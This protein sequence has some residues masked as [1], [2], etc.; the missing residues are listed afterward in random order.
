MR[1]KVLALTFALLL[2]SCGLALAQAA[3]Q[4]QAGQG[5]SGQGQQA[6]GQPAHGQGQ[7]GPSEANDPLAGSPLVVDIGFRVS[8]VD[9]DRARFERFQDIRSSGLNLN[10]FGSKEGERWAADYS[11]KNVGYHDQQYRGS[12]SGMGK[13]FANVSFFQLPLN[14]GFE[15]DG[16]VRTAYD[17][18]LQLDD[19]TQA[20]AQAGRVLAW[21]AN[22]TQSSAWVPLAHPIDLGSRRDQLDAGLVY[23]PTRTV[24]VN[25]GVTTYSRTGNQPWGASWGFSNAQE[26]PLPLDNRTTNFTVGGAYTIDQLGVQLAFDHSSFTNN[27]DVLNWD[28][29]FALTDSLTRGAARGVMSVMPGNS[30][31]TFR[32]S[33]VY[34]LPSHTS[35]SAAFAVSRMDQ[36]STLPPITSNSLLNAGPPARAT[37]QAKA[38]VG[39]FNVAVNSRP[40]PK[41]WLTGRFR[42]RDFTQKTPPYESNVTIF[43]T[44]IT[45]EDSVEP[46]EYLDF[47]T[48][49]LQ[50]AAAYSLVRYATLRF[51]YLYNHV[52]QTI[53]EWPKDTENIERVSIDSVGSRWVTLRASYEHARRTGSGEYDQPDGQQ[54][55]TRMFD[56]ADRTRNGGT[57]V[58]TVSPMPTV[59]ISFSANA[60]K[61]TYDDPNQQFGLLDNK[62][63]TYTAGVD[64]TPNEFV[65]AGI[66]YGFQKYTALSASRNANP[67]PD[68][69]FTDPNRNW[70]DNHEEKVHT[71]TANLTVSHLVPNAEILFGYD[72]S[73][74]NQSYLY[75]G[76]NILRLQ[77]LTPAAYAVGFSGQ[78][79][80]LPDV[81]NAISRATV[82]LRYFF[83]RQ[84][85]A[86]ITYWYDKYTVNDYATPT[87]L[88]MPGSLLLGYGW[89]PYTANTVFLNALYR[90]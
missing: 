35:V 29:P 66:A 67:P 7:E 18:N 87:R 81:L 13:V 51:D 8:S 55:A 12:F 2:A 19:A 59:G 69:S 84:L 39:M 54:P 34:K 30:M 37:A 71:L 64:V 6:Q 70:F 85:A 77:G 52:T 22:P 72:Y 90:F 82:N 32:G 20:A 65:S 47:K 74:S 46:S 15:K 14:Y 53:R 45:A 50:L 27:N 36:D 76:P 26:V 83:S 38:D 63:Q 3:D 1:T 40:M 41:L 21:T 80:Q 9:G 16:F 43:D 68:P 73:H 75:S 23:S 4:G 31:T 89:R 33:G 44:S 57:V 56:V 86:N 58:L 60:S 48:Q 17:G 62:N 61:D 88:D 11:A 24:D 78:F 28:N 25:V 42:W 79:A 49:N 10:L 5:Q